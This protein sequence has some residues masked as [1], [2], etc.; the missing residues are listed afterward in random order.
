M[1]KPTIIPGLDES[2]SLFVAAG[3]NPYTTL[4]IDQNASE[5]DVSKAYK[6]KALATH[7]DRNTDDP[8]ATEN[9]KHVSAANDILKDPSKR[10]ALDTYLNSQK[11]Q[12]APDNAQPSPVHDQTVA[13]SPLPS[14]EA[15]LIASAAPTAAPTPDPIAQAPKENSQAKE[16]SSKSKASKDKSEKSDDLFPVDESQPAQIQLIQILLQIMWEIQKAGYDQ[17]KN[18]FAKNST[19]QNTANDQQA[20]STN[21]NDPSP[22]SLVNNQ[23]DTQSNDSIMVAL[24]ESNSNEA[25]LDESPISLAL[26]PSTEDAS[27]SDQLMLMDAEH[28]DQALAPKGGKGK[29]DVDLDNVE[30]VEKGLEMAEVLV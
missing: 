17:L 22:F 23:G 1:T 14:F 19:P 21:T 13:I 12:A 8:Y 30:E 3:N 29:S 11:A 26:P 28:Y 18:L 15:T 5:R 16:K 9:F 24:P 20:L 10:A 2:Q 25:S 6:Q 7:P 4:G 27:P